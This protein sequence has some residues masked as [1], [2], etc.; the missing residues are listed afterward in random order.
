MEYEPLY[1]HAAK[2]YGLPGLFAKGV[3][4]AAFSTLFLLTFFR[5][6]LL[7]ALHTAF[8]KK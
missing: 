3:V 1:S 2:V 5:R 8:K 7:D 4:A 6:D